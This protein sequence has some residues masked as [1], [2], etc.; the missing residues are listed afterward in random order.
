V[1]DDHGQ[2]G[3]AHTTCDSPSFHTTPN[4]GIVL[5]GTPHQ[6]TSTRSCYELYAYN[7]PKGGASW[8]KR[9]ITTSFTIT[10]RTSLTNGT[11][12]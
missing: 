5:L 4:G 2:R 3:R 7:K 8:A 10:P 11:S 6:H 1:G 12:P 9:R